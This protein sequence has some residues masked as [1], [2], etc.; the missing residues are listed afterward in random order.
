MGSRRQSVDVLAPSMDVNSPEKGGFVLNMFRRRRAWEVRAGF[1]QLDQRD[2]TLGRPP[3]GTAEYGFET[4]LGCTSLITDFGHLQ[5][6]SVWSGL[7]YT[8][9]S[10]DTGQWQQCC[11]LLIY[12]VTAGTW[13]EEALH[14]KTAEFNDAVRPMPYWRGVYETN[15]TEDVSGFV[16]PTTRR[17]WF[18]EHGDALLFGNRDIGAWQYVPADFDSN[19]RKQVDGTTNRQWN[20]PY[21]ESSVVVRI[22]ANDGIFSSSFP[23]LASDAFPRPDDA[24]SYGDRIVY[25]SKNEVFFTDFNRPGS[26]MGRNILYVPSDQDLVGCEVVN[27]QLLLFSENETWLYQPSLGTTVSA[28]RLVPM[29]A[30]VGALGAAVIQRVGNLCFWMDARGCYVSDGSRAP[31]EISEPLQPLFDTSMSNPLYNYFAETGFSD[32]ATDQPRAFYDLSD[33]T[34]AHACYDSGNELL[35]FNL[36]TLA[37]S[38]VYHPPEKSWSVWTYESFANGDAPVEVESRRQMKLPHLTGKDDRLFM[39]CGAEVYTTNDQAPTPVNARPRSA[40]VLELGRGGAIDR[41]VDYHEDNRQYHGYWNALVEAGAQGIF[42]VGEPIVRNFLL[43]EKLNRQAAPPNTYYLFPVYLHPNAA[44]GTG[45]DG[46]QLRLQFD[47]TEWTPVFI[48]GISS[49]LDF[50]LPQERWT[51]RGG[52]GYGAPV[53]TRR[54]ECTDGAGAGNRGGNQV[55]MEFDGPTSGGGWSHA[56]SLNLLPGK[57]NPLMWLPFQKVS[58]SDDVSS[59]DWSVILAQARPAGGAY[60]N[61]DLWVFNRMFAGSF[62][63]NDDVAQAVDWAYQTPEIALPHTGVRLRGL[64]L[65]GISHGSATTVLE[66]GWIYGTLNALFGSDWKTW[67]SQLIDYTGLNNGKV[68]LAEVRDKMAIRSRFIN[69]STALATKVFGSAIATWGNTANSAHGN[70]LIDDEQS[71]DIQMSDSVKGQSAVAMIF[72]HMRNRA[73]GYTLSKLRAYVQLWGGRRRRGR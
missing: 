30:H 64:E 50:L 57:K 1:G 7:G 63:D 25:V 23:Y 13:Y 26:I 27:D 34:G 12:D 11:W 66:D 69:T 41:S 68:N 38:L 20:E 60:A 71:D 61:C 44:L 10:R 70:Y 59:M 72:G 9:N 37:I 42:Y 14:H 67:S 24:C 3:S 19:R 15:E 58:A 35:L 16:V 53:A 56:N 31:V 46:I 32:L 8:G 51:S 2:T 39:V 6:V 45:T 40:I 47:N 49:E 65:R 33:V 22:A 29:S 21:S 5:I 52:W 54:V 17:A 28:G 43:N 48:D 18:H 62:H 55:R 4:N 36:P 73:E